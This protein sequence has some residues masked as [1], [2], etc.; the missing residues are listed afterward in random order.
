MKAARIFRDFFKSE[1]AGGFLLIFCAIASVIICNSEFHQNYESFW[2]TEIGG[3]SLEFWISDGLMSIFFL[4]IGLELKREFY[5]GELSDRAAVLPAFAA[6]GGMIVPGILYTAINAG[7]K[8]S[9][10]AGI[11][12]ATDIAFALGVLSLLGSRIPS[13]VKVFLTALAVL[14]DLGAIIVI[15]FFYS[16]S[17]SFLFLS[18]AAAV[19]GLLFILNRL[20]VNGIY[21]YVTGGIV[22]WYCML[23]SGIHP[24]LSG[25]LL[26]LVI[27]LRNADDSPSLTLQSFLHRPVAFGILP[28]FALANSCVPLHLN[29][30]GF[31]NNPAVLGILSG[32]VLGKP[33]GIVLFTLI[34]L[35]SGIADLPAGLTFRQIIGIGLLGGIGFTMSIF[36]LRLAFDSSQLVIEAKTAVFIASLTSAIV[37][38]YWL[39]RE[40][41]RL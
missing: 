8:T 25:V 5:F 38:Y 24:T 11:P 21:W 12:V 32:L 17:L 4:L 7:T 6:F 26:G 28:L 39:R 23:H 29:W 40:S 35:R 36:I 18:L 22:L 13:F 1:Q 19:F 20:G 30:T 9:T 34:A 3:S 41:R 10:G 2:H 16:S 15:A 14:D 37:G 31:V 27:P 33:I